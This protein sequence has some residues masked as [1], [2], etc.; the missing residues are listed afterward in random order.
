M[1]TRQAGIEVLVRAWNDVRARCIQIFRNECQINMEFNIHHNCMAVHL[2]FTQ[3]LRSECL[4]V[5][6]QRAADGQGKL[7]GLVGL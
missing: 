4:G 6:I 7:V 1:A 2:R 3:W 5:R